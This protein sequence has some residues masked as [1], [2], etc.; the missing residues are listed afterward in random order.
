MF[1]WFVIFQRHS[2]IPDGTEKRGLLQC[3]FCFS[4]GVPYSKLSATLDDTHGE[5]QR[6]R[7]SIA[8]DSICLLGVV[9]VELVVR[10]ADVWLAHGKILDF[11]KDDLRKVRFD[12]P[13][14]RLDH[15]VAP[16]KAWDGIGEYGTAP[17]VT[18]QSELHAGEQSPF[19][20]WAE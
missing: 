18:M 19:F 6:V 4:H 5:A 11:P 15:V 17:P 20:S 10:K 16:R 3:V 1:P 2:Q 14:C 13:R 12:L 8:R 9:G 7:V